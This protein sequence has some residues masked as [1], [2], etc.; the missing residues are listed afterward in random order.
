MTTEL[1][2]LAANQIPRFYAGGERIARFRGQ[3]GSVDGHSPE[4]W[5]GSTVRAYG[6]IDG[7]GITRLSDGSTLPELIARAPRWLLGDRHVDAFGSDP[8]LLVKLL[9]A[10]QRLPVH[11]HPDRTFAQANLGVPL[12]KSE[13][14]VFVE[15]TPGASVHIGFSRDVQ[16]E[17]L[18][19]WVASQDIP[20]MLAAMNEVPVAADDAIF[21]PAGVPHVIG[22]GV[23]L[24]ELQEPTDLSILLE[25]DHIVNEQDAYLGLSRDLALSASDRNAV[26]GERL[27][28]LVSTR[29]DELFPPEAD[30]FFRASWRYGGDILDADYSLVVAVEGEGRIDST[31]GG[32]MELRRGM[33]VLVPASVGQCVLTGDIRTLR[34]RP[35]SADD[36]AS[37]SQ[38]D[39]QTRSVS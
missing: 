4:D 2:A 15:T 37:V 11:V 34:C 27:Q 1:V 20:A 21:I 5:V 25:W 17:E 16:F 18:Q 39:A 14:W 31:H 7:T 26:G 33:T 29:P 13:A 3:T 32:S 8:R 38:L 24:I 35:P 28:T 19:R 12:G 30:A 10:G 9:D 36:P 23:L 6:S 22:E